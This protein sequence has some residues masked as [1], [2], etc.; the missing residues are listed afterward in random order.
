MKC[1][2]NLLELFQVSVVLGWGKS[3]QMKGQIHEEINKYHLEVSNKI[4][5]GPFSVE[6]KTSSAVLCFSFNVKMPRGSD[7]TA[8]AAPR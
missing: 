5:L 7:E 1:F 8:T 2:L 6:V 4:L 3:I